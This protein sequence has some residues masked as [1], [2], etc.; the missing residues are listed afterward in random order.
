MPRVVNHTSRILNQSD[1]DTAIASPL[2]S[3]VHSVFSGAATLG[4]VC[5]IQASTSSQQ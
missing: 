3:R 2:Q 5:D 1:V 4:V